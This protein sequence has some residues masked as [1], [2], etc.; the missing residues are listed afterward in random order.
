MK[1]IFQAKK[2]S[3]V[4]SNMVNARCIINVFGCL[5]VKKLEV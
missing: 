1:I 4:T 3:P 5:I 2:Y